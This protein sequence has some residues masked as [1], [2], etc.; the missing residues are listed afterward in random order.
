MAA[1]AAILDFCK[2]KK[3]LKYS[4]RRV[5]KI[6]SNINSIAHR[7]QKLHRFEYFTKIQS[8]RGGGHIGFLQK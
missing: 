2:N 3:N 1:V 7:V 4:T 5:A 8:G 6:A